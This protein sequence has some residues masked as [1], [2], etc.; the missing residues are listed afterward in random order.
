MPRLRSLSSTL[1]FRRSTVADQA[2][3]ALRTA[4]ERGQ[5]ANPLPGELAL[6]RRLGVSRPSVH[7]ALAQLEHAGLVEIRMGRRT[8]ILAR[9]TARS[10]RPARPT[11]AVIS[12]GP[13]ELQSMTQAPVML[14]LHAE[15]A[16]RGL[17][18]DPVFDTRLAV[19]AAAPRLRQ[20]VANR[21]DTCWVL[22]SCP[23]WLQH[24]FADAHVPTLVLG[25]CAPGVTLPSVDLDFRSVGWHAAGMLA[26]HGHR[27]VTLV[28]PAAPQPGDLACREG[29]LE[30]FARL[31]RPDTRVNELAVSAP[32]QRAITR[33]RYT[34][35]GPQRATA[36]F[37][38]REASAVAAYT[39]VL[40]LGLR[41]PRDVSVISRDTH[42]LID[43][44]LPQLTRYGTSPL[45]QATLA[46]RAAQAVL[47]GTAG[48]PR[49]RLV[50]PQYIAG[51]TLGP[52]PAATCQKN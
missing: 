24:W 10:A 51:A 41:V 39:Q 23:A 12:V 21:R 31:R 7:A 45:K 30:Y 15:A 17:E 4:I 35:T 9:G 50:A 36:V 14:H 26:R 29:F 37:V 20:L 19:P 46:I 2:A 40:E 42:P 34:L 5:L 11:L 48:R 44:A 13:G 16:S 32:L 1:G 6:A 33:L 8:R 18:W 3:A 28:L 25:T 43:A 38:M 22:H 47:A 52:V 27:A 49:P